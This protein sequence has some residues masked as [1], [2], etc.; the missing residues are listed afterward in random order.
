M[1][2]NLTMENEGINNTTGRRNDTFK[3][4]NVDI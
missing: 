1:L 4:Y 2:V 3:P